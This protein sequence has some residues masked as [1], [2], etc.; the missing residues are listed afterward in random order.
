MLHVSSQ[1]CLV[2]LKEEIFEDDN[3]VVLGKIC[4]IKFPRK[5]HFLPFAK[6]SS[7]ENVS[8][9]NVRIVDYT[10]ELLQSCPWQL[11]QVEVHCIPFFLHEHRFVVQFSLQAHRMILRIFSGAATMSDAIGA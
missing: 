3:F 2:T 5:T 6:F 8:F 10:S 1:I 9:I 11:T 7:H 4:E